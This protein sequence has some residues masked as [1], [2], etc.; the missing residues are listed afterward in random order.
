MP[1]LPTGGGI[2]NREFFSR[3]R[4]YTLV[5]CCLRSHAAVRQLLR[6]SAPAS[7]VSTVTMMLMTDFQNCL[8]MLIT[9][10]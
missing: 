3:R 10:F 6:H 9:D 2:G 8:S 5:A 1:H 7:A 4:H